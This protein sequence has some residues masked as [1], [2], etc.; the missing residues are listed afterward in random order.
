MIS[1]FISQTIF[2]KLWMLFFIVWI[3][4]RQFR[5]RPVSVTDTWTFYLT[6]CI[7]ETFVFIWV[8]VLILLTEYLTTFIGPSGECIT[9]SGFFLY[10]GATRAIRQV[11]AHHHHHHHDFGFPKQEPV[12]VLS[13]W[14]KYILSSVPSRSIQS[15]RRSP[16]KKWFLSDIAWIR[17]A[18]RPLPKFFATS[19]RRAFY[20]NKRSLF[21]PKCQWFDYTVFYVLN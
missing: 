16:R 20:V 9:A 15:K 18:G 17:G 5:T 2:T 13:S 19:S 6:L 21:L 8:G 7:M 14:F 1:K 4:H 12:I 10:F 11:K 3:N